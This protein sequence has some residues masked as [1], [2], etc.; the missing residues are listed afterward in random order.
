VEEMLK[1]ERAR[2]IF[3]FSQLLF[4]ANVAESMF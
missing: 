4:F 3:D 2:E 1:S